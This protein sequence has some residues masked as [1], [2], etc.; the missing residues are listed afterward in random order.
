MLTHTETSPAAPPDLGLP[1]GSAATT[2]L[3][4]LMGPVAGQHVLVVGP[5]ALGVMCALNARGAVSV[6]SLPAKCR[7]RVEAVDVTVA[8]NV[9]C[10]DTAEIA[11]LRAR[12]SGRAGGCL[13]LRFAPSEGMALIRQARECLVRHGFNP[14]R[15]HWLE[16]RA[17]LVAGRAMPGTVP[18][19]MR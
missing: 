8:P 1:G 5:G 16:D 19:C 12:A 13:Y 7:A 3:L 4:D 6:M 10:A 2:A 11:I 18:S 9:F 15:A 14:G 17:V